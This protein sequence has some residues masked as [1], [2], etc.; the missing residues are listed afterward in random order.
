MYKLVKEIARK[1]HSHKIKPTNGTKK[2]VK[3]KFDPAEILGLFFV[4]S[5]SF[6]E[7]L[8][9]VIHGGSDDLKVTF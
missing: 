2:K 1:C 3:G 6:L 5:F 9:I 4:C 7:I 8:I